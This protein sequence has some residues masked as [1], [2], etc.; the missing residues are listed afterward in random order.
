MSQ[1]GNYS[2]ETGAA[3]NP[4]IRPLEAYK[5]FLVVGQNPVEIYLIKTYFSDATLTRNG[6]FFKGQAKFR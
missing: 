1:P 3:A 5:I 4:L 6:M 2:S